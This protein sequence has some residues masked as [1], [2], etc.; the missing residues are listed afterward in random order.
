MA[1]L[2]ITVVTPDSVAMVTDQLQ[3]VGTAS[4]STNAEKITLAA[5]YLDGIANG[6][7]NQT[8]FTTAVS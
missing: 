7:F 2:V 5:R 8:S 1:T 3:G 4:N 6:S